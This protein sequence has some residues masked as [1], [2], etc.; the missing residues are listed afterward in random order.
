MKAGSDGVARGGQPAETVLSPGLA[1][2]ADGLG[3]AFELKFLLAL[4]QADEVEAWARRHLAPDRHGQ[5][6]RYRV[7]SVYCDTPGLDVFHRTP[8]YR[9]TKF[10]VR[11]Y[12]GAARV[13]LERKRKRGDRVRKQR[14][15]V[16]P[17]ELSLLGSGLLPDVI[18]G[19][20][21]GPLPTTGWAGDWF[22][23]RVCQR[24]LRPTACV[25]YHRTA[26]FGMADGMPLRMT[27]DRDLLGLPASDW[28]VPHDVAG[29]RP[30]LPDGVLLELKFHINMPALYRDLLELLPLQQARASKYRRCVQLCGIWDGTTPAGGLPVDGMTPA[31]TDLPAGSPPAAA[32]R[33]PAAGETA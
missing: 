8:G 4:D 19:G 26:F 23:Q 22:R 6:G 7:T 18:V 16:H 5:D 24:R 29:G 33:P 3:P 21:S 11:R 15:D 20:G 1:A 14:V 31:G 9:R 30:L 28:H 32:V 2:A 25:G 27:M 13:F 10:R 17:D 12:D